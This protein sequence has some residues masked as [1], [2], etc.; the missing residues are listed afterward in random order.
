VEGNLIYKCEVRVAFE[1]VC[2]FVRHGLVEVVDLIF[3]RPAAVVV[4]F[5]LVITLVGLTRTVVDIAGDEVDLASLEVTF[6]PELLT[7]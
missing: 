3:L 5:W 7:R 6:D 2:S 4:H 1:I